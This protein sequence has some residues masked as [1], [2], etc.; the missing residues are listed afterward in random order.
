MMNFGSGLVRVN[1]VIPTHNRPELLPIAVDSVLG[2]EVPEG[3]TVRAVVVDDASDPPASASLREFGDSVLI[4]RNETSRGPAAARNQ[5]VSAADA[6]LVAFLD[7]DD[8]WLA[9]K[10]RTCLAGF[11]HHPDAVMVFHQVA[12]NWDRHD[13]PPS[14][15]V[16]PDPVARMLHRQPPH[17]DGVMVPRHV[18]QSVLFDESFR[19]S[20]DL[21]YLLRIALSGPVVELSSTLA[22]HSARADHPSAISLASRIASRR[23]FR[24]KHAPLF[25]RKAKAYFDLRIGH[26]YRRAGRSKS[27]SAS[28]LRSLL[29]HPWWAPPWKG[30]VGLTLSDRRVQQ[31]ARTARR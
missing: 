20:E 21:D 29:R 2:Q 22:V 9:G 4:V 7:D 16:V 28:F 6:D 11:Q 3:V 25:D 19:A 10:I 17:L 24:D 15:S 8:R 18:H 5:G 26:Q 30:L 13:G 14:M 27:A 23:Q 12:F 1:A 31:I